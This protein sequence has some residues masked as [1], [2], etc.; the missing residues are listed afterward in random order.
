MALDRQKLAARTLIILKAI[1]IPIVVGVTGALIA[2]LSNT[3]CLEVK[4]EQSVL[5][6]SATT[7]VTIDVLDCTVCGLEASF[8]FEIEPIIKAIEPNHLRQY[9]EWDPNTSQLL[10]NLPDDLELTEG[11]RISLRISSNGANRVS[12]MMNLHKRVTAFRKIQAAGKRSFI[13]RHVLT[14]TG[15]VTLFFILLV[16]LIITPTERW[17]LST[18]A[19]AP[20][21]HQQESL[22]IL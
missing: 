2:E 15:L 17:Y 1:F 7:D 19:I 12:N 6:G 11:D 14:S 10:L 4:C 3:S 21:Q 18:K 5:A 16:F 20:N 13:W 9:R 8:G 22:N